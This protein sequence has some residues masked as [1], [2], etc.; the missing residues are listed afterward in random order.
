MRIKGATHDGAWHIWAQI[1]RGQQTQ[2]MVCQLFQCKPIIFWELPWTNEVQNWA[3]GLSDLENAVVHLL[4]LST[5]KKKTPTKHLIPN[6]WPN[7]WGW[8]W[9]GERSNK[10]VFANLYSDHKSLYPPNKPFPKIEQGE[11]AWKI[12]IWKDGSHRRD[13]QGRVREVSC[14]GLWAGDRQALLQPP[15]LPAHGLM[16]T[17]SISMISSGKPLEASKSIHLLW[18]VLTEPSISYLSM[19]NTH[20]ATMCLT[21]Y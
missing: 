6:Y 4:T 5:S 8:K 17:S 7:C 14:L 1:P 10:K 2:V 12:E 11:K 20:I 21:D 9:Q 15:P 3:P 13:R 18:S 19:V 16:L